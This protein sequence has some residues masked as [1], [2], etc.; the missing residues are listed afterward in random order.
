MAVCVRLWGSEEDLLTF[1]EQLNKNQI[2][3]KMTSHYDQFTIDFLD[4][5]LKKDDEGML[6][7]E[8]EDLASRFHDRGYSRRSIKRGNQRAMKSNR[9]ELLCPRRR[10]ESIQQIFSWRNSDFKE[11]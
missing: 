7:T 5:R 1:T 8:A 6:Q 3:V 10:E 11:D 9:D 4:V 2:N